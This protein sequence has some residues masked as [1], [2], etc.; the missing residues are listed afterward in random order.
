MRHDWTGWEFQ[1]AQL[2]EDDLIRFQ[3]YVENGFLRVAEALVKYRAIHQQAGK[4][5]ARQMDGVTER[6]T[7]Y[8]QSAGGLSIDLKSLILTGIVEIGCAILTD[9]LSEAFEVESLAAA[10]TQVIGDGAKTAQYQEHEIGDNPLIFDT[11]RQYVAAVNQI[12][13]EAA[14]AIGDLALDVH[15]RLG[16]L[17][18]GRR[19]TNLNTG[20]SSNSA[21]QFLDYA[22]NWRV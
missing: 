22:K 10:S 2:Y 11:V 1:D 6:F 17:E 14:R 4:D 7:E 5:I 12:E 15:S 21:P 16:E 20:A 19:Y 8:Q 18:N 3:V 13:A 9:G